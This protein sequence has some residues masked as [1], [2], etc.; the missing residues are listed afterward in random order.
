MSL[1]PNSPSPDM[2]ALLALV[3][4]LKRQ[5]DAKKRQDE[6]IRK[7]LMGPIDGVRKILLE[8]YHG[9]KSPD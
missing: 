4:K 9:G 3:E 5:Q 7:A 2:Q 6:E 1:L 8:K